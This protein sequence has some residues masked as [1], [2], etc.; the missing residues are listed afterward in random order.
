MFMAAGALSS[1]Y[2]SS[3]HTY[4]THAQRY[5]PVTGQSLL[6]M[7]GESRHIHFG[8]KWL[9]VGHHWALK[10]GDYWY[11]V[12]GTGV[13][14]KGEANRIVRSTGECSEGEAYPGGANMVPTSPMWSQ[15][16]H[17]CLRK[18]SFK[19]IVKHI[20]I[21]LVRQACSAQSQPK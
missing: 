15:H 2:L 17:N 8:T 21:D 12:P 3:L 9:G 10:V 5:H 19:L 18:S 13:K 14:N 16:M 11:E 7:A 20:L 4:L 6:K 1:S